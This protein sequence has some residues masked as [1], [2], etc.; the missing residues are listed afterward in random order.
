MTLKFESLIL[1]V[2]GFE[3]LVL[4]LDLGVHSSILDYLFW[5]FLETKFLLTSLACISDGTS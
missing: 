2:L 1:S 3:V 5:L 4:C